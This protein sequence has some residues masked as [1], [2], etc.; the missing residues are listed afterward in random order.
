M[1]KIYFSKNVLL[2]I[3]ILG[4]MF[5]PVL[6]YAQHLFSINYNDL[7]QENVAQL[8][9]QVSGSEISTLSLTLNNEDRAVY[10]VAFSAVENTKIIILNEENGNNVT[11]TPAVE[12]DNYPSLPT[13]FQLAPF[14]IEELRQGVLGNAS[15]YVILETTNDFS[16]QNVASVSAAERNVHIPRYLYGSKEDIKEAFPKDRQIMHIFKEK[17]QL[18]LANP[19]DLD[20]Q[21][22]AAQWEEEMSYYVYMYK[23]P[24]GGLWIYDEHFN[25]IDDNEPKTRT[26]SNLEFILTGNGNANQNPATLHALDI[27]SEELAGTVPVA[28]NILF[29]NMGGGGTIGGSYRQPNYWHPETETWYC[30]AVGNQ[31]AGYNVVP[32]QWDI[33]IE[34]NSQ[35]NFYYGITGDPGSNQMDWITI[36]L[37]EVCHGLGF[38]PLVGTTGAYTYTTPSG[39]SGT[40]T[41]FPGIYDRQLFQGAT[42]NVCLTDLPQSQRSTLV[43]SNNLYSGAPGS[44]LLEASDGNRV[45]MFAPTSWQSGSSVSHWENS[46]T[47]TTF[48][49]PYANYGWKLHTIC[50][51]TIGMMLDIGW[52]SPGLVPVTEIIN[53]PDT[54]SVGTLILAGTVVPSTATHKTINWD[55]DDAGTTGAILAG[56]TLHT[57]ATGTL[58]LL[59]TIINGI[60][61]DNNYTQ[62]F[63]IT[64][65]KGVQTAPEEPTLANRTPTSIVLNE[66]EDCEFRID[67]EEWQTATLFD[68]LSPNTTYTF[69]ARKAETET[70]FAS[71]E[72][73][74]VEFATPF[75]YMITATVN[76]PD[77]GSID[78][79]GETL[80][81]EGGSITYTITPYETYKIYDVW[82]NGAS[83]GEI[84]TYTFENVQS[85]G[86]ISVEFG[87]GINENEFGDV[88]VYSYGNTV[89]IKI[90]ETNYPSLRAEITDITGRIVYQ[91]A[92]TNMETTI[93]LQVAAGIYNVRLIS[94]EGKTVSKKVLIER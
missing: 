74:A 44:N 76:D 71:P 8:K 80:I 25:I 70:H 1:S 50:V 82:V 18:I 69:V 53:V 14:F 68:N 57:T 47:F 22:Y 84:T 78:P 4:F 79:A 73:P 35:F 45:Q 81:E 2:V 46:V 13:E 21:R 29:T 91:N 7:S 26:G 36:I 9:A 12:T 43:K 93:P 62:N 20:L 23:L 67:D 66:M 88:R 28:I 32:S 27:W 16:V 37:H 92:I 58:T 61:E 39:S 56:D 40:P 90:V 54:I 49:R 31:M 6:L 17:P 72:S 15:R 30:S 3:A 55:I 59:A 41:N 83:Q 38:Y 87:L 75:A 11:I 94:Q 63:T 60:A 77:F 86:T 89:Y 34:M 5:S 24:D 48:M 85:E 51:R 65:D 52:T 42:G 10:P 33:R 64:V 19:N